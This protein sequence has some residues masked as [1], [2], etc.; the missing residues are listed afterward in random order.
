MP[1]RLLY[2][3]LCQHLRVCA[4]QFGVWHRQRLALLVTGLL[5]A[6]HTALPRLA[7]QLRR[8]TP[9]AHADSIERRL[10]RTLASDSGTESAPQAGHSRR[11]EAPI[12]HAEY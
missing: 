1:P 6:R 7:A 3:R 11:D 9:T 4:P 2:Q 5:L 8:V 10:R 12:A